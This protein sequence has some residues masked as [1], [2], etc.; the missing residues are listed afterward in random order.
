MAFGASGECEKGLAQIAQGVDSYG[1]GA[2]Q[3]M[4]LA[5][6]AD[7]QLAIGNP[8]AVLASVAA[9]LKAVEKTGERRLK[10]SSIGSKARHCSPAPG[11]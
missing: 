6:Q 1:L 5:F 10:R 3:H 2:A 4:L 8:E 9:G 11:R 7:A